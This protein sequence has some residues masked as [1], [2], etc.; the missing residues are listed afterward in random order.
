MEKVLVSACL[1][2]AK[3]RYHG[4]DAACDHPVLRRWARE[5]RLVTVCPEQDGGLPTPRPPAEIVGLRIEER[6]LRNA[7]CGSRAETGGAQVLARAAVVRTAAGVDVTEAYRRG[8][9]R[10]LAVTREQGIRV[11][12]LKEGSPSCGSSTIYDGTFSEARVEGAGV[13]AALLAAH[14]IRVFSEY[15]LDAAADC[16]RNLEFGIWD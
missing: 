13:T 11:A 4:G 10:A 2:G 5:G 9:D 14:G 8:A 7:D 16:I 12:V 15:E 1:L 3:V 6:G